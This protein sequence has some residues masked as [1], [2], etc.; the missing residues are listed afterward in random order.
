MPPFQL[1]AFAESGNAYKAALMLNACGLDW[2]QTNVDFF[3]GETRGAGYRADINEMGEVPVLVHPGGKL[4]QSGTILT[5]LAA[6][7]GKFGGRDEAERM[8]ILSWILF[9]NHKFTSYLATLRFMVA[10]AKM[11]KSDVTQF[12]LQRS[13]AAIAIVEK[14]L[15]TRP[16]MVGDSVTIADFSL[17]GYLWMPE[18]YGV[19]WGLYPHIHAWLARV[20]ATP[21]WKAPYEMLARAP[22]RHK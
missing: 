10:L 7:T 13:T 4:A 16:Y 12:L 1:Y 5:W 17:C 15:A 6:Q 14:H 3:N 9:D 21:G 19:D 2:H 20:A 18:E 11:P 22:A 8:E